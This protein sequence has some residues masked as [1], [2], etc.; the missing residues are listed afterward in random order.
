[1][2]VTDWQVLV[3]DDEE[4]ALELIQGILEFQGIF[5]VGCTHAE[6]AFEV[7]EDITPTL[8]IV[9]L[10]LPGMDG[11]ALLAQLQDHPKLQHVPRVAI[12]SYHTQAL[13]NKAIEAGFDAYFPKPI[14]ATSFVRELETIVSR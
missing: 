2:S 8:V 5:S 9:D 6:K 3:I 10:A 11:W 12:T 13:A 14:D 7:L 4:D 1:M